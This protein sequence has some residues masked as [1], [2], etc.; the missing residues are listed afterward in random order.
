L[1]QIAF[2]VFT[3]VY[4]LVAYYAGLYDRWY[5]RSELVRS[6]VIATLSLLAGYALLPEE[7]RFSRGI[8]L[9]GALLAFVMLSILRWLLVR[10]G[11]L[12]NSNSQS[13]HPQTLVV[14]TQSESESVAKLIKEAGLREMILGRVAVTENDRDTVGYYKQLG[15]LSPVVPYREI[16]FCEGQLSFREIISSL[17]GLPRGVKVKFHAAGSQSI[18]GSESGYS[19]GETLSG[20]IVWKLG[21]PYNKR[22]KRLIDFTSSFLFLISFPVHFIGVKKPFAF[23]AN[24]CNVLLARRTW[25]GYAVNGKHLP[26]LRKAVIASNG[27]P[28]SVKQQLPKE[29]LQMVDEWYARDYEPGQDIKRIFKL[30]RHL[31]G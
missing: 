8:L 5:K 25:I 12:S 17:Q 10:T 19:S 2:P 31:G 26:F 13:E 28:L 21:D 14:G 16:I 27:I 11:V 20:D 23:L 6:T 15:R 18:V 4:L 24:C 9:F 3:L 30:Y 1:L 29:S 7:Y 22:L